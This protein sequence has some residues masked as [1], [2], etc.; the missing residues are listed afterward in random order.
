MTIEIVIKLELANLRPT[1]TILELA[2]RSTIKPEGILDDLVISVDSWEY[3]TDFL[4]LQ[5][6][7]HLGGHPLIL[8]R[9]WLAT[10]D[11][12]I[13]CRSGSM[14]ISDG[15]KIKNLTLYPLARPS[16]E[17]E[18]LLWMELEEEEGIQPLLMIGKALTFKDETEDDAINNFISEP[19]DVNKIFYQILNGTLGEEEQENLTEETLVSETHI[20]PVLKNSKSVP[21]K[22]ESRKTLNINPILAL[23]EQEFLITLFKKHKGAFSWEYT[24][25]KGILSNMCTHHI[26]IKTDFWPVCQPQ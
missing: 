15:T 8:G 4:V 17:A 2:D 26:Y 18:T 9:P 7:S 11:S 13:S 1:P 19:T 10:V 12:C 23:D 20:V 22:V 25:M 24:Y 3:P 5:P 6:K 14:T 16:L 21:I